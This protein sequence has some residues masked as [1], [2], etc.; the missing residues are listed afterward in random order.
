MPRALYSACK[1]NAAAV[2]RVYESVLAGREGADMTA[3]PLRARLLHSLLRLC[4]AAAAEGPVGPLGGSAAFGGAG[5]SAFAGGSPFASAGGFGA[6]S[7]LAGTAGREAA[8]VAEAAARWG[9]AM[10]WSARVNV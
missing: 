2:R 8:L 5:T 7:P 1:R 3:P 10:H 9:S 4:E 6:L